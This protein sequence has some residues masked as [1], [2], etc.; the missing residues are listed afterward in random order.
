V[1]EALVSVEGVEK[2]FAG[3]SRPVTAVQDINFDIAAGE[4]V[5]IVGP[6][7]CGKSTVLMMLAGLMAPTHGVVK[8]AGVE[9]KSPI[10]DVGIMFQRDLLMDWRTVIENVL[11][12]ADVRDVDRAIARK[13]AERLLS[14]AGLEGFADAYPWELS[15]GM[16]QRTALCRALLP[17]VPLLLLDEPFGALDA[18]TRDRMN[19]DLQRLWSSDRRTALLITHDISEAIFLS[20]RV[21]IMSP[22]PGRIMADIRIDLPH[23]R[24]LA[25]RDEAKFIEY[26]RKLRTMFESMAV[27]S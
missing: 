27:P 4:F 5:S 14:S 23:P 25:V 17:D 19:L 1:S 11:L 8:V 2:V 3:E 13:K 16:R 6:S 22:S 10:T 7:G 12:Q 21:L 18:M 9:V 15:G 20:D 26:K 24:D